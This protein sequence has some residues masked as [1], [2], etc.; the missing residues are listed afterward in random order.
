MPRLLRP[1]PLFAVVLAACALLR[2]GAGCGDRPS[3]PSGKPIV[4]ATTTMIGDLVAR[5][6]GDR[7]ETRVL[8]P[9]GTDPHTF[10]PAPADIGQLRGA[11]LVFY[12][13]LHLEGT[14]VDLF[15]DPAKLQK[16]ST[17]VAAKIPDDRLLGWKQGQGGAHD[18]HVWFDA[19]LWS[20]AAEAVRDRLI[21]FDPAGEAGYRERATAVIQSLGSLHSEV[22][23]KIA[24]LPSERRVLITS[25]DAYNYFSRAYGI[26]VLGIQG[27]STETEAGLQARNAAVEYILKRRV[28]AI[29]IES[30]VSPKTI[31]SVRHDVRQAG[32]E[33]AIGGEL[34]SDAMGRPGDHPGYAVETYEGMMRYNVDTIVKALSK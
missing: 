3:R 26:E 17:A 27:I 19:D 24:S 15:E 32:F 25:H 23:Q 34:Y 7:V 13:G 6:G 21:Q 1:V 5:I 33:V 14:M 28:P 16:K 31:E 4:V 30:S 8:M 29:F 20:L 12:N 22:K 18:P 10:K 9:P 11:D 2:F